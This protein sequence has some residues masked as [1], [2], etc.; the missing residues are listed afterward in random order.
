MD[1]SWK[2][3]W[4]LSWAGHWGQQAATD[5]DAAEPAQPISALFAAD[6]S[7]LHLLPHE[8]RERRRLWLKMKADKAKADQAKRRRRELELLS[9]YAL[10]RS[11]A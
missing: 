7:A 1:A 3:S 9:L 2:T 4:G 11:A 10:T 6:Q 5:Q 8:V